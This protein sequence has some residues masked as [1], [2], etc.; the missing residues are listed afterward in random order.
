MIATAQ[1][2]H[3]PRQVTIRVPG[4]ADDNRVTEAIDVITQCYGLPVRQDRRNAY[5]PGPVAFA[6]TIVGMPLWDATDQVRDAA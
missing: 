4:A 3:Q 2:P 1:P 6:R 5:G